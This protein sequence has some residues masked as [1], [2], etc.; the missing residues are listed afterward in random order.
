[1]TSFDAHS[2]FVPSLCH[3]LSVVLLVSF[4]MPCL[5]LRLLICHMQSLKTLHRLLCKQRRQW[6][7]EAH[8]TPTRQRIQRC[9]TRGRRGGAGAGSGRR[10]LTSPR[11]QEISGPL[12][13]HTGPT[14][15]VSQV[16]CIATKTPTNAAAR[17]VPSNISVASTP[18]AACCSWPRRT[19]A[20]ERG[21]SH[22]A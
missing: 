15:A 6:P 20:G 4:S 9:H 11:R 18:L 13:Q 2:I 22:D 12:F 16:Q 7:L 1:M 21:T 17:V 5:V 3:D 14:R 19:P 10:T 8:S